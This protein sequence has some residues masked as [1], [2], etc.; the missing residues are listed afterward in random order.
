[1][2]RL[3][4][5]IVGITAVALSARAGAA[6]VDWSKVD[7]A[8]GKPST[9]QPGG[10]HKYGLPRTDLKI[11][12]DGVAIKPALALGSWIGFLP[13]GNGAM[14]M[15]DLVLTENEI[16]PVMKRLIDDGVE[17]T[18]IH[19][20][21]LRTTPAVFYM[22]VGGQGDPVKLA[23]TLHA[24]LALSQTPFA[25]PAA[26][27]PPVT[28][29]LD[30]AAIDNALGA[31][32]SVNGGVYQFSIPRAESISEDGMA[33]PPSMGTAIAINFQ[34]TGTGKAA[35]TGDFVLLG[36][37]VNPVLKALRNNGIEV[38][39]LHSHM[40]DDSPHLFFMHFW[41]NDDVTKLTRGLRAALD[42]ANVKHGS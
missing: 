16:S 39:A 34:P 11:T 26:A 40:I 31:K 20:H 5:L 3:T 35:I 27:Q 13:M 42:L 4:T 1:M 21:L 19:N 7:Q 30:T 9:S 37:E 33:V 36:K 8:M 17:I 10:V 24:G 22:H 15:G 41:A 14:F 6:D 28:L 12:V 32:G 38:T 23:Q 25:A 18:A 29:D 2:P